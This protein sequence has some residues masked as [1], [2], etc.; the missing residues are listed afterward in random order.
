VTPVEWSD[1]LGA[2]DV[3]PKLRSEPRI[4]CPDELKPSPDINYVV[5]ALVLDAKGARL[6]TQSAATMP[7]L[8]RLYDDFAADT[9]FAPARR[10]KDAVPAEVMMALILNPA[11]ASATAPDATPRLLAVA[12]VRLARPKDAKPQEAFPNRTVPVEIAVDTAG[13]VSAIRRAPQEFAEEIAIAA[14]NWRFAPARRGGVAVAA[15]LTVPFV[16]TWPAAD[17]G[18]KKTVPV[19]SF[20]A[21]PIYPPAMRASGFRGEVIVDFI[22]DLEGRVRNAFVVS[23]SNPS[24]DDAALDAVERWRFKPGQEGNRPVRTHMRVP[25]VFTLDGTADGG[26]EGSEV[27]RKPDLSKLPEA[28]RYDTA[29]RM[30]SMARPVYPY[31]ALAAGRDGHATVSFLI[32][33]DG[34]VADAKITEASGPEFG[35]AMLAM[36]DHL[37]FEPALKGG[38]PSAALSAFRQVFRSDERYQIVSR[39]D[40]DLLAREKKKPETIFD[41]ADLDRPLK[42]R[43]RKPPRLPVTE[44]KGAGA[45]EALIEFLIDETGRARLPRVVSASSEA[46]GEAAVIGVAAWRFEPPLRGGRAVV[47]RARVPIAFG[48]GDSSA[49]PPVA[50]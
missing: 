23:S 20:M 47:V 9:R 7:R 48:P 41:L 26:S 2:P 36:A 1:P 35:A 8:Q 49:P 46:Y 34:R 39:A 5:V 16:V 45:G 14:K 25:I 30:K 32:G 22:V 50:K 31:A 40:L 10:D 12:P 43:S 6:G 4:A 27:A 3:L 37:E 19:P 18:E 38:R 29:P 28:L 21:R 33:P 44:A 15:E 13:R 24:F 17:S 11:S 42:P